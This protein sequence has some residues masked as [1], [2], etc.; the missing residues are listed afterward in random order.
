MTEPISIILALR[1]D[2]DGALSTLMRTRPS[3]DVFDKAGRS[4]LFY[5]TRLNQL[6]LMNEDGCVDSKLVNCRDRLGRTCMHAIAQAAYA[7]SAELTA[8]VLKL[9]GDPSLTDKA[10]L[11]PLHVCTCARTAAVLLPSFAKPALCS[12]LEALVKSAAPV[13]VIGTLVKSGAY[14]AQATV[15]AARRGML[16]VIDV[17]L[18]GRVAP[19]AVFQDPIEPAVLQRVLASGVIPPRDALLRC[20]ADCARILLDSGCELDVCSPS[21]VAERVRRHETDVVALLLANKAPASADAFRAAGEVGNVAALGL[22]LDATPCDARVE[23]IRH[24]CNAAAY[25]GAVDVLQYLLAELRS[26]AWPSGTK[27]ALH[28]ACELCQLGCVRMLVSESSPLAA[29]RIDV[30][31]TDGDGRS[32]LHTLA[33]SCGDAIGQTAAPPDF[34]VVLELLLQSKADV[35]I[36]DREGETAIMVACHLSNSAFVD[37]LWNAGVESARNAKGLTALDIATKIDRASKVVRLLRARSR[38]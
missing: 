13:D 15:E 1:R 23:C 10:K 37:A 6:E 9:K 12:A 20:H 2:D 32:A 16:T 28:F 36:Q 11:S 35:N 8:Y 19:E 17:L 14:S 24:G 22:L 5:V 33:A 7:E 25:H 27:T 30:N 4:P 38:G 26:E 34:A 21:L 31:A 29:P 18:D 3:L